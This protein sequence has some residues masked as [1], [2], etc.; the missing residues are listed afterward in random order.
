MKCN[1]SR[2]GFELVSLCPFAMMITITPWAP[3]FSEDLTDSDYADDIALLANTPTQAE[4]LF[5]SLELT[6]GGID[7]HVNADEMEYMSFTQE[8]DISTPNG[9]SLKLEDKFMYLG[10]STSSTES[11]INKHL[12]KMWTVTDR[13]SII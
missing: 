4:F 9:G 11:D 6:A 8:G 5:H 1:Q 7:P 13:L 2:L 3:P 10:S 12:P